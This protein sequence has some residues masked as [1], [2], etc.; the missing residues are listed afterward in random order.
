M[1]NLDQIDKILTSNVDWD[2]LL[3]EKMSKNADEEKK[4]AKNNAE[5]VIINKINDVPKKFI[6]SK[7]A[8]FKVF[9]KNSKEES[10][11]NGIQA[12]SLLG[13]ENHLRQKLLNGEIASFSTDTHFVTFQMA[14]IPFGELNKEK[15]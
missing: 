8:S 5:I 7:N 9:S 15:S 12:D 11:V 6:L 3:Q 13:L 2:L 1:K 4:I 10:F 14:K